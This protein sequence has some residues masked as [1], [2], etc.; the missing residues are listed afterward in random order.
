[1][2]AGSVREH[3]RQESARRLGV[4]L[5]EEVVDLANIDG[6]HQK[7]GS[8]LLGLREQS[9]DTI[10]GGLP[11]THPTRESPTNQGR[12]SSRSRSCFLKAANALIK[13]RSAAAPGAFSRQVFRQHNLLAPHIKSQPG[14]LRQVQRVP[15]GLRNRDLP[16]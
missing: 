3:S 2:V 11:A 7:P 9:P 16:L 6:A 4:M 8:A 5:L 1:M 10:A 13:S 15:D 12:E 14:A